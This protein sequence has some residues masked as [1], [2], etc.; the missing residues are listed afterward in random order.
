MRSI[1]DLSDNK[2]LKVGLLSWFL[3][4]GVFLRRVWKLLR[5]NAN[6]AAVGVV[7]AIVLGYLGVLVSISYK[8]NYNYF[9]GEFYVLWW[10]LFDNKLD[11]LGELADFKD[12]FEFDFLI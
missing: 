1:N 2:V 11:I 5:N 9:L 7:P 3:K 8:F 10:P 6:V 12:Y 4:E